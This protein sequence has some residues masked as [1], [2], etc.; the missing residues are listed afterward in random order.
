MSYIYSL[1]L[2]YYEL[3]LLIYLN[4]KIDQKNYKH[5]GKYGYDLLCSYCFVR[6]IEK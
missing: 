4:F 5:I 6:K 1:T 3:Y 2:T